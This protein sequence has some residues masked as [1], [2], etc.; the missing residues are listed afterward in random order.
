[1]KKTVTLILGANVI[2][3][4]FSVL[5]S[6]LLPKY[7][8][9][10]SYGYYKVYQLYVS[11]IGIM[12]FGFS[13]GIYLQYG[14]KKL[15]DIDKKELNT[16]TSTIKN[17]QLVF[18][19]IGVMI[20]FILKNNIVMLLAFSLIPINMLSYYKNLFQATGEFSVY[21]KI[22]SI[23]PIINFAGDILFLL[24]L[25]RNEYVIYIF[26]AIISYMIVL[27]FVEKKFKS[28]FNKSSFGVF[29][30]KI[31]LANIKKGSS[32]M[33]GNFASIMITSIDRWCIQMLME[34]SSFSYYSFAV[35]VENLINVCLSAISVTLYNYFCETKECARIIKIK[36]YCI[37]IVVYLIV[38]TFP[39]KFIIEHWLT[40]YVNSINTLF[41]LISAHVFYFIIKSIYVNIY[42]AEGKQKYYFYQMI[43]ILF[44]A[45][46]TNLFAYY[47]IDNTI[48]MFA[49]ATLFTAFIWY[50][51]C[52]FENSA[53]R[54]N[55][56][57]NILLIASVCI[58]LIN[59]IIIDSAIL[60]G[61]LYL[62]LETLLVWIFNKNIGKEMIDLFVDML[63]RKQV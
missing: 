53:I 21:A 52:Y 60:G 54:G 56:K 20:A 23:L 32:L 58:Y 15:Q 17:M 36:D 42:K 11:Y 45:L 3:M 61:I 49:S 1:M 9:I 8:T 14:G 27:A 28:E 7:L 31:L 34:I 50:L 48:E 35:S 25:K 29:D 10:D 38:I 22:M 4:A 40:K 30:V 39:I 47:V 62:L 16:A 44:I 55:K 6:F 2:N 63:K 26:T 19:V 51:L 33:L 5:I 46:A 37:V 57:S 24:L 13:D 41:I 59:G 12:H 18:T 43:S